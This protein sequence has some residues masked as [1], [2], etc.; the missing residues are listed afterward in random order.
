MV[1]SSAAGRAAGLLLPESMAR[2]LAIVREG[3]CRY[4]KDCHNGYTSSSPPPFIIGRPYRLPGLVQGSIS[5]DQDETAWRRKPLCCSTRHQTGKHFSQTCAQQRFRYPAPYIMH[6][7]AAS[8]SA[9][10]VMLVCV[11]AAGL[12]GCEPSKGGGWRHLLKRDGV[13]SGALQAGADLQDLHAIH[14]HA[15]QG[16]VLLDVLLIHA[17][18]AEHG[19]QQAAAR[20]IA[21]LQSWISHE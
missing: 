2:I 1:S 10:L 4:R 11:Q 18:D 19:R 12:D 21:V 14:A 20:I 16:L 13:P 7:A 6:H 8:Q 5:S 9:S 15:L 3:I 17:Q